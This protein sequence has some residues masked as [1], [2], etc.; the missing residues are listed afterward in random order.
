MDKKILIE[1]FQ[2]LIS[3]IILGAIIVAYFTNFTMGSEVV[4]E[5]NV[6]KESNVI[7]NFSYNDNANYNYGFPSEKTII[8][9]MDDVQGYAYGNIFIDL[10]EEVLKRNMSMVL[11]VIPDR[12]KYDNVTKNYLLSKINSSQIEIAMHG[13]THQKAYEKTAEYEIL[14]ENETYDLGQKG[15]IEILQTLNIRPI[16]FIP[17]ENEY[18]TYST[19]A[20]F[21]LGFTTISA[22][23]SEYKYDGYLFHMGYTEPTKHTDVNELKPINQILNSCSKSLDEKNLCIVLIHPQDYVNTDMRTINQTRFTGF[24]KLLDGLSELNA[25]SKTF[26]NIN[27]HNYNEENNE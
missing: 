23:Q 12:I 11:G 19:R 24:K 20:L 17:P 18:N 10:T 3:L 22:T 7:Y 9:R 14:S 27:K 2:G 15:L 1:T 26:L 16:T 6:V 25:T 21:R 13:T 5:V 8:L 4:K